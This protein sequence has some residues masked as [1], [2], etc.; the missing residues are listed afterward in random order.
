MW[1]SF[2]YS[3]S[4][5]EKWL[6]FWFILLE[7]LCYTGRLLR[8]KPFHIGKDNDGDPEMPYN[9]YVCHELAF[10]SYQLVLEI[11]INWS[12][13]VFN[14]YICECC[15]LTQSIF[16]CLKANIINVTNKLLWKESLQ[17]WSTV[18]SIPTTR[19]ITSHL[20][21]LN[22]EKDHDLWRLKSMYWF[23]SDTIMWRG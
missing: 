12:N 19:T 18:S 3:I 7:F 17:W 4:W 16:L 20:N 6:L 8:K 13:D 2:F 22:I 9:D 15:P 11:N 14:N 10:I 1:W 5:G 21:L 23:G